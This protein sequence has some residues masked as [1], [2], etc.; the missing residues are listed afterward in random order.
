MK[1][2]SVSVHGVMELGSNEAVKRA[3]AAN[4][5]LGLS[6]KF[7]VT[8]DTLA[9]FIK[10]LNVEGWSCRRPL[11]VFHR[12]DTH[13]PPAQKAFLGFLKDKK[14]MPDFAGLN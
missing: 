2:H 4:L 3:V 12:D 9:G 1:T 5:G 7:G 6:S 11:T 8:P 14:P 10:V 13:L